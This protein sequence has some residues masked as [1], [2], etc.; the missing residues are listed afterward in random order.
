LWTLASESAD[1]QFRQAV[2]ISLAGTSV[3]DS[4]LYGRFTF[5]YRSAGGNLLR[6]VLMEAAIGDY[7]FEGQ[8]PTYGDSAVAALINYLTGDDGWIVARDGTYPVNCIRVLGKYDDAMRR[9]YQI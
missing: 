7:S 4:L 8:P 2:D 3:A 9:R 5:T 1:P 6:N